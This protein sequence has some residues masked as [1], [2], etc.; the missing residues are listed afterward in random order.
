MCI[1]TMDAVHRDAIMVWAAVWYHGMHS[2]YSL[3]AVAFLERPD[4]QISNKQTWPDVK[5][6]PGSTFNSL[7]YTYPS[8][9]V[10]SHEV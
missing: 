2:N 9:V 6:R 7:V 1:W 10:Y 5:H 3:V 8:D 4:K